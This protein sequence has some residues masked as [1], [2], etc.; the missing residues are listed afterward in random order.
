MHYFSLVMFVLGIICTLYGL[1]KSKIDPKIAKM[2][3]PVKNRYNK[4]K[5][6]RYVKNFEKTI[7]SDSPIEDMIIKGQ[8]IN[9]DKEYLKLLNRIEISAIRIDTKIDQPNVFTPEYMDRMLEHY[10]D[11]PGEM[12]LQFNILHAFKK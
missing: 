3:K 8:K 1:G 4:W 5:Y 12:G 9:Y 10:V 7:S 2:L 11:K 6:N